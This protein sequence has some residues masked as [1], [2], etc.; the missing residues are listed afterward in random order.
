VTAFAVDFARDHL[1]IA[2]DTLAYMPGR[3][4][5]QPL[6]FVCKIIPLPQFQAVLI[7][8]GQLQITIEAAAELTLAVH[9]FSI[10]TAA[11]ALPDALTSAAM[12]YIAGQGVED[13]AGLSEVC[14][15]G[16]S[17]AAG[18]MRAWQYSSY[19]DFKAE[20]EDGERYGVLSFPRVPPKFM[21]AVSSPASDE[22]LIDIIRGVDRWFQAD[23]G[24][25]CNQRAG[26]EVLVVD[27]TPDSMSSRTVHRFPDYDCVRAQAEALTARIASGELD[28]R[29]VVRDGV[30]PGAEMI[31]TATGQ[32]LMAAHASTAPAAPTAAGVPT[33]ALSRQQRRALE[34][35]ASKGR[36]A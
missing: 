19:R 20:S 15:L 28:V 5:V 14:L 1:R 27:I 32:P 6:G 3:A 16:W 33:Q 13:Y 7:S 4:A 11:A 8:R 9:L 26:G 23:P 18:R 34:R 17:P 2:A 35:A 21:P 12:R 36:V 30:V 10:E 22:A 31:D 24:T 29:G 25:N